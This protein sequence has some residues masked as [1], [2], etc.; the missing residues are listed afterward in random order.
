M[1]ARYPQTIRR[2][3]NGITLSILTMGEDE[4]EI[5]AFRGRE[6]LDFTDDAPIH[7]M[8]PG[9]VSGLNFDEVELAAQWLERQA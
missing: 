6:I 7:A 9:A 3:P 5:C 2:F 1:P 8:A 4:F